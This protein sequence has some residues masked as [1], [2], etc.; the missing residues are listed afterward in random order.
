MGDF[1]KLVCALLCGFVAAVFATIGSASA[2][3]V[4]LTQD[5]VSRFLA[6]FSQ[7]RTIAVGEGLRAGT[8][9]EAA[10]NPVGAVVKAIKSSKLQTQA[11]TIAV[12][13]G[14][15]DLKEWSD[16]GKAIGQAY[17]FVTAGP[18]QGVARATLDKNKERA[19]K[20]LEKF[21]LINENQKERLKQNLD[22]LADQLAK[23]PPQ[24]NVAVVQQMKPDI[25]AAVKLGLD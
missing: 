19:V 5:N 8:D 1:R 13:H 17:V 24:Q 21:G 11:K 10:K 14:F 12:N 16:T 2:K 25:E 18:A 3:D 20:E 22:D 6:S 7:M 23:E 4:A 15:A 9:T